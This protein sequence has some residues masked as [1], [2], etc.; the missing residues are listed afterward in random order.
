MVTTAVRAAVGKGR[1]GSVGL[2]LYNHRLAYTNIIKCVFL[3]THVAAP[4]G[5]KLTPRNGSHSYMGSA[6]HLMM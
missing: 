6:R 3:S 5:C 2:P 1:Q 4:N